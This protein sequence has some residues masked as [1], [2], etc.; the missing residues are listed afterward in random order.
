MDVEAKRLP[1]DGVFDRIPVGA[2]ELA[3]LADSGWVSPAIESSNRLVGGGSDD[4]PPIRSALEAHADQM[5]AL[6]TPHMSAPHVSALGWGHS[7]TLA[8]G[9]AAG[10]AERERRECYLGSWT[11]GDR[12]WRT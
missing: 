11:A 4:W 9:L 2:M 8:G 1:L 12:A 10:V 7:A 5:L 3:R 6:V